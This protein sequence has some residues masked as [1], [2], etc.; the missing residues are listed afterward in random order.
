MLRL[1]EEIDAGSFGTIDPSRLHAAGLSS[2]AYMA[3]RAAIAYPG[4]FRT[5][6]IVAGSFATCAGWFCAVPAALPAA[7]PPTLFLHGQLDTIVPVATMRPY[8]AQLARQGIDARVV[9]D[10]NVWH[11]WIPAA[12][13]EVVAWFEA[14][15]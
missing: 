12:P 13:P 15:R 10:P 7:H 14:P 6:A 9:V 1:F 11:G 8:A 3:S 4:R 5:V 2:G